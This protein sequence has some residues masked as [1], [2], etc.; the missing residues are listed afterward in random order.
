MEENESGFNIKD[1]RRF[2]TDGSKKDDSTETGDASSS[3]PIKESKSEQKETANPSSP[4]QFEINFSTFTLSLASSIQMALGL[5]PHPATGKPQ[6]NLVSARQTIDILGMLEEK[7]KGNLTEE[8]ANIL[9]HV[10]FE[11][12]MQY[13]EVSNNVVKK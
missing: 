12:R 3:E 8:E 9:K 10:L 5:I 1:R 13:V 6:L 4:S 11:L 2:N 7:T